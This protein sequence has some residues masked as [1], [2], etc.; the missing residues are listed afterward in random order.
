MRRLVF[1]VVAASALGCASLAA[2][3]RPA[4]ERRA[5][6][7]RP[8]PDPGCRGLVQNSLAVNGLERVVV[9]VTV[10]RDG[11][12]RA[13]ELAGPDLTPAAAEDVRRAFAGCAWIPAP[14]GEGLRTA[15]VEIRR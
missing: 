1:V 9:K 4:E 15:T 8:E 2:G 3:P 6:L 12:L 5:E 11:A 13:L 14:D 7:A 10:A